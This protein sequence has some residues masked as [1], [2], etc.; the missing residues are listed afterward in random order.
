VLSPKLGGRSVRVE[1][2]AARRAER[3]EAIVIV[4]EHARTSTLKPRRISFAR[5]ISQYR[6]Q[7]IA[8]VEEARQSP[9]NE[10]KERMRG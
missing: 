6:R 1:V 2:M 9:G 3:R 8:V 5:L 7:A 10:E 4:A